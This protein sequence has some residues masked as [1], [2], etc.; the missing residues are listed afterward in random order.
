MVRA[1][2]ICFASLFD[3]LRCRSTRPVCN[4]RRGRVSPDR[5]P[6]LLYHTYTV[7][8]HL[9]TCRKALLDSR[10]NQQSIEGPLGLL[11][12]QLRYSS[13]VITLQALLH[14][15]GDVLASRMPA[16]PFV[17][18]DCSARA[19]DTQCL[20]SIPWSDFVDSRFLS[21]SLHVTGYWLLFHFE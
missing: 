17:L 2:Y 15:V 1:R 8:L 11:G 14:E 19:R 4:C 12:L 6:L 3:S 5:R 18:L 20:R 13:A 7:F 16:F 9:A 21:V 10:L